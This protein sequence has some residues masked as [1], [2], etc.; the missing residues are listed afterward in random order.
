M[1]FIYGLDDGYN[2]S[3]ICKRYDAMMWMEGFICYT[4]EDLK[5]NII[6]LINSQKSYEEMR[7]YYVK[8]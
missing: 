7:E 4:I 8:G 2:W 1:R 6:W 5:D 3:R